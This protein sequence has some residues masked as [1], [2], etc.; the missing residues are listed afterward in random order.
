MSNGKVLV[1]KIYISRLFGQY[2]YYLPDKTEKRDSLS[3]M[4]F[5]Y[6]D[7]GC[8]KTTILLLLFHSLATAYRL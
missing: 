2:D 3:K 4:S 7:N 5:L 8:G 6:G 1:K